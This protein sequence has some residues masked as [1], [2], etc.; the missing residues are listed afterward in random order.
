AR[1]R[2]TQ[3][4]VENYIKLLGRVPQAAGFD[5]ATETFRLA[6]SVRSRSVQKALTAAG[7]RMTTSDP[8]LAEA[9]RPEQDLR[10]QIGTQLGQLNSL[11]A[12]PAAERD[13]A[14]VAA[15]RKSIDK[16]RADHGKVRAD[17][18]KRF[19]EYSDLIDPKPP[20][21]AQ[22]KETLKPGEALL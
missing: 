20:T 3:V 11:L 21:T 1:T 13:D 17:I 19:P 16:M 15:I 12:L 2:F 9:G 22:I 7:A 10:Q 6:D 18:D 14:G 8:K 4:V 5:V